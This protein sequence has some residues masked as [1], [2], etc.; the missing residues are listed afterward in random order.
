MTEKLHN[1]GLRSMDDAELER[2]L[3]AYAGGLLE[4][5]EEAAMAWHIAGDAAAQAR[6]GQIRRHFDG[7]AARSSLTL[8]AARAQKT[9]WASQ[10]ARLV[11]SAR[12]RWF[13]GREEATGEL[14]AG[15][16]AIAVFTSRGLAALAQQ[17]GVICSDARGPCTLGRG[18]PPSPLP[19][20][21]GAPGQLI[22]APDG[23]Q[24]TLTMA[25]AQAVDVLV[26]LADKSRKG[27][28]ELRQVTTQGGS[29]TRRRVAVA[30]LEHGLASFQ[31]TS[32]GLL[33]IV[34]PGARPI[35]VG[36][37]VSAETSG[38]D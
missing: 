1:Y 18:G 33:E 37:T 25:G 26:E 20:P 10:V 29:T 16:L 12:Q 13:G 14:E 30:A 38:R 35:I 19:A 32:A 3:W 17:A 9:S 23:T 2:W 24:V 28:A 31:R 15:L 6:L 22:T 27:V 21:E 8:A 36:V 5:D 11:S 7:V 34:L 4:P